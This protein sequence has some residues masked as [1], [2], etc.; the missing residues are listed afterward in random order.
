MHRKHHEGKNEEETEKHVHLVLGLAREDQ[1]HKA[2]DGQENSCKVDTPQK[3]EVRCSVL[4]LDFVVVGD[5]GGHCREQVNKEHASVY[6]NSGIL[7]QSPAVFAHHAEVEAHA[8]DPDHI[9]HKL[10][11]GQHFPHSGK[12]QHKGCDEQLKHG[13]ALN[14]IDVEV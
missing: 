8:H 13:K 7:L 3:F 1:P 10:G 9:N 11:G 5:H 4:P 2:L 6:I 12:D 14:D